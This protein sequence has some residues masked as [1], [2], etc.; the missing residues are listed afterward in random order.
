MFVK[1]C[2]IK[3]VEQIQYAMDEG[4]NAVGIVVYPESRRF[5]NRKNTLKLLEFAKGKIKTVVVSLLFEHVSE[6]INLSDFYQ[7]YET[8]LKRDN[9]NFIYSVS[10]EP[11][12]F[13]WKYLVFDASKGSGKFEKFPLWI[14]NYRK[15]LILA[16]GLNHLN[17]AKVISEIKPFGVDVSSGVEINGVKNRSLMKKFIKQVRKTEQEEIF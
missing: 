17:V 15:R 12:H 9:K 13:N 3:T 4:Y 10:E 16:G 6:Y 7:I 14:R 2:G 5:S 8:P 11:A 1:V